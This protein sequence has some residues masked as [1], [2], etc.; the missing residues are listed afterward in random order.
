MI[1]KLAP[2]YLLEWKNL[3]CWKDFWT[4]R[5]SLQL[6]ITGDGY[7]AILWRMNGISIGRKW[8]E[9][10]FQEKG[11]STSSIHLCFHS[12]NMGVPACINQLSLNYFE[13]THNAIIFVAYKKIDVFLTHNTCLS[14][15]LFVFLTLL[16]PCSSHQNPSW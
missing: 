3:K 16:Q 4:E 11:T 6:E 15:S 14:Q 12:S 7:W 8:Q 13:V 5:H 9:R 10:A 1:S 2:E